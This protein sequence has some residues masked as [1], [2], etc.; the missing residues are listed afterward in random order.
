M[1]KENKAGNENITAFDRAR[2]EQDEKTE[3]GKNLLTD[4]A[5]TCS[6]DYTVIDSLMEILELFSI[7]DSNVMIGDLAEDLQIYL[8]TWTKEHGEGLNDWK[9]SVL[10]G[11]KYQVSK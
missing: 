1:K 4:I 6:N 9:E 3:R 8:F 11:K 5:M 7:K 10:S 2:M